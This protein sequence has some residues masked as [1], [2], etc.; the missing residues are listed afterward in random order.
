MPLGHHKTNAKSVHRHWSLR[1]ES[2]ARCMLTWLASASFGWVVSTLLQTARMHLATSATSIRSHSLHLH[3]AS[4]LHVLS[5][6]A[7]C[8]SRWCS[9]QSTPISQ[10]VDLGVIAWFLSIYSL[11]DGVPSSP[12]IHEASAWL[13][14]LEIAIRAPGRWSAGILSRRIQSP[15]PI[16]AVLRY[17][18]H[19]CN[20]LLFS[21]KKFHHLWPPW[22][23][24]FV[25]SPW[26][27]QW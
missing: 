3:A 10:A 17:C 1:V 18:W 14:E 16:A 6:M 12:S 4:V 26:S 21:L 7:N 25:V 15:S 19:K 23:E 20:E 11:S 24:G 22:C 13:R 2:Q 9:S 8:V 27:H 5:W